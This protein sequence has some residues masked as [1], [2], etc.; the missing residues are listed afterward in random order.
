M[1]TYELGGVNF[2]TKGDA[3]EYVRDVLRGAQLYERVDDDLIYA[4]LDR[5]PERERKLEGGVERIE[6]RPNEWGDRC[7]T[8]VRPSGEAVAFS[9]RECFK[10]STDV[11][12]ANAALRVE[13]TDQVRAFRDGSELVCAATGVALTL[14]PGS[15]QSAE[16]DHVPPATFDALAEEWAASIGGWAAVKHHAV[17]QRRYLVLDEQREGWQEFHREHAVL[18]LLS[19]A[20][21]RNVS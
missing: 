6:V 16:V 21:H 1:P 10:P 13:I 12:N 19:A 8:I 2:R 4:L 3:I 9:F 20:T 17:S 15:P 5:H 14:I 18:R 11:Q 7:F